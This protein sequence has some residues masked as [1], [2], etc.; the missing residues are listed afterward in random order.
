MTGYNESAGQNRTP[1]SEPRPYVALTRMGE[2]RWP[3]TDAAGLERLVARAAA[4]ERSAQDEL[5]H[6]Y[7]DVIIMVVRGRMSRLGMLRERTESADL[8]QDAAMHILAE[9][10]SFRWQGEPAFQAWV[11]RLTER[12]VSDA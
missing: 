6:R 11:R 5:L 2:E 8:A 12:R 3:G 10:P 9:L 1:L 4:G 7:W